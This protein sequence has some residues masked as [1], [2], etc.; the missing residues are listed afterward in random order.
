MNMPKRGWKKRQAAAIARFETDPELDDIRAQRAALAAAA[1]VRNEAEAEARRVALAAARCTCP[2]C[3]GNG[4]VSLDFAERLI[5]AMA[6]L[7][8][9]VPVDD[10]VLLSL[11]RIAFG[12]DVSSLAF[13][14]SDTLSKPRRISETLTPEPVK[15]TSNSTKPTR[16][17][18]AVEAHAVADGAILDLDD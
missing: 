18:T 11:R 15:V 17:L 10:G 5:T 16:K 9:H 4:A 1:V 7:P 8:A 3:D 6:R 12:Q 2:A 13:P 14:E